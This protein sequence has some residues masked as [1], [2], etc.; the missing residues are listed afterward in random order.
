MKPKKFSNSKTPYNKLKIDDSF[1]RARS[2]ENRHR[3]GYCYE[4]ESAK[5]KGNSKISINNPKKEN[6]LEKK[7][8]KPISAEKEED[9]MKAYEVILNKSKDREMK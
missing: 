5:S 9:L 7:V 6:L 8:Q 4:H 1:P 2:P 3:N